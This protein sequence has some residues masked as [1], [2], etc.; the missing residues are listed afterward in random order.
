[1]NSSKGV[2]CTTSYRDKYIPAYERLLRRN[3][4]WKPKKVKEE[5]ESKRK[6]REGKLTPFQQPENYSNY[7]I[8]RQTTIFILDELID[9]A[10][11]TNYFSTD[12]EGDALTK[13][14]ATI[15]VE[16]IRHPTPPIT[17]I[18]EA[19]HL[20]PINSPSF[21]KIQQLCSIIFTSDRTIYSWGP[22][23]QEL[24]RFVKFNL[25]NDTIR[26]IERDLQWE[27]NPI[28]KCGL[29]KLIEETFK[30]NLDKTA[31]LGEWSC[32]LDLSLDTYFPENVVGPERYYRI[33]EEKKYRQI[34]KEYAINDV[35]AVTKLAYR[36]DRRILST[37]PPTIEQDEQA[38]DEEGL[39]VHVEDE[40]IELN[41]ND[42]VYE[43]PLNQQEQFDYDERMNIPNDEP[44]VSKYRGYKHYRK[45][46]DIMQLHWDDDSI[47]MISD[48][49][50]EIKPLPNIMKPQLEP[51]P[52]QQSNQQYR[53][54]ERSDEPKKVHV[55]DRV[56][57]FDVLDRNSNQDQN[58][59]L[60]QIKNRKTNRRHRANRYQ[61]EV[62]RRIYH[63][64]DV[65]K[66]K[67][68]LKS[69][70]IDYRNFNIVRHTLFV[71]L[72]HQSMVK[73][74]EQQLNHRVFTEQHH[75]RLY[76]E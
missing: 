60:K 15:Q 58:L 23:K 3:R 53:H 61:F 21:K 49:E 46:P 37:P 39:I 52:T 28:Q 66:V 71:G 48:D 54:E 16:F 9:H 40:L 59:T 4:S 68:I 1:M 36:M 57:E 73:E 41:G 27:H 44:I 45:L 32:G 31:T 30:Q 74:V 29:K 76:G 50:L 69:M 38:N 6:C 12:T 35:F 43:E 70:N 5:E 10:K 22:A 33:N 26:I 24:E 13:Q 65:T 11:L 55:R 47:E 34:L 25:F 51:R 7:F 62:I 63:K 17:I 64:F 2:S 72:K 42:Y 19:N 20:P 18:I 75:R 56:R 67:P 8:N 14:P